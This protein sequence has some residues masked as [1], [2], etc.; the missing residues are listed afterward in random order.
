MISLRRR[1]AVSF[2]KSIV[3]SVIPSANETASVAFL[4]VSSFKNN[5][6]D[7]AAAER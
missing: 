1:F 7:D 6:G 4:A 2:D 5:Y 3:R